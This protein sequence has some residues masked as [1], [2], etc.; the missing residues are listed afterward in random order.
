L[1]IWV[2]F[3]KANDFW[4]ENPQKNTEYTVFIIFILPETP[5]TNV[6]PILVLAQPVRPSSV[7]TSTTFAKVIEVKENKKKS[8]ALA[9][10]SSILIA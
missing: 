7:S 4:Q 9:I 3:G 8:H 1:L 2:F 10:F 6:F 5:L